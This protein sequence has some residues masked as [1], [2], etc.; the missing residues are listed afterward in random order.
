MDSV[1]DVILHV[2]EV[3]ASHGRDFETGCCWL[4]V[5]E[6]GILCWV[7]V[8][9]DSFDVCYWAMVAESFSPGHL[10]R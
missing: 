5:D 3:H 4:V 7:G 2:L 6:A 10:R 8:V 1:L 9:G